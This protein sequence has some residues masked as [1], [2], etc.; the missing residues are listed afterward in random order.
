[1][2]TQPPLV[3]VIAGPNGAGKSTSAARLLRDHFA[4]NE[5][6]NA[7][8]IA[9]GLSAY[10]PETVAIAAGRVMLHRLRVLAAARS[11]LAFET[12]LA[13]RGHAQSLAGLRANGY[14]THLI[15]LSLRSPEL[16]IARVAAR[17]RLG[18]HHVDD[19][20]VHRRFNAGLRNLF[21]YCMDTVDGW[22]VIDGT[23]FD[24]PRMV[25][26]GTSECELVI[27][28][29]AVWQ[30]M[31][32]GTAMTVDPA[33]NER[34]DPHPVDDSERILEALLRAGREAVWQHKLAGNP[35]ANWRDGKV[36][37]VQPDEIQRPPPTGRE[38]NGQRP[39]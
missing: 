30:A 33:S 10:R 29:P 38:V 1:M 11:D 27:H 9:A 6:V 22:H 21:A 35:V 37:W 18:G 19:D 34:Q 13:G 39:L 8:T 25:A 7:D 28:Q 36:H 5:F 2:S 32:E 23:K 24:E 15:Y 16:A 20:V 3:V 14:R 26:E 31:K 4:V 17:V 12:T